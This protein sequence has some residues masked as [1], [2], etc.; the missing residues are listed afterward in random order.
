MRYF[1]SKA[2][3]LTAVI[4]VLFACGF[5]ARAQAGDAEESQRLFAPWSNVALDVELKGLVTK[6]T[7]VTDEARKQAAANAGADAGRRMREFYGMLAP[8]KGGG[9]KFG[10]LRIRMEPVA[11]TVTAEALRAGAAE[12]Y[13]KSQHVSKGSI[14]QYEYKQTPM[15]RFKFTGPLPQEGMFLGYLGGGYSAFPTFYSVPGMNASYPVLEAYMV[16]DGTGVLFRYAAPKLDEKDEQF[17]HAII[18]S[19]RFFDATGASSSYDFFALGRDLYK[20]RDYGP[21]VTALDKALALER[22]QRALPQAQWRDLVMTFANALG[23]AGHADLAL[24]V[25]EIGV[26][27]EPTYPYFHHGLSRLYAHLRDV[28][29]T[30]SELEKT[31]Q[32]LPKEKKGFGGGIP[33][34]LEDPAYRRFAGDQKFSDG[35]KALKKKYKN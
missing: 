33:D 8:G 34:P 35:V 15:L 26:A 20:R 28:D 27:E 16:R 3:R 21:A 24:N 1:K 18:D 11:A 12:H 4:L 32:L 10:Y 23:A 2:L 13:P 9:L 22:R 6:L 17:F 31:Y 19:V 30:L 25:L 5:R 7:E 14:K 29:R